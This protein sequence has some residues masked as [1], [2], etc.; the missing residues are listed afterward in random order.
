MRHLFLGLLSFA[1]LAVPAWAV[2]DPQVAI[3]SQF[4]GDEQSMMAALLSDPAEAAAFQKEAA[5]AGNPQAVRDAVVRWRG[6]VAAYASSYVSRQPATNM[7]GR[8]VKEMVEP[9][10]WGALMH[11]LRMMEPGLKKDIVLGMI[12]DGNEKLAKGDASRAMTVISTAR[13]IM[14]DSAEKYLQTPLAK[15]AQADAQRLAAAEAERSKALEA[16]KAKTAEKAKEAE[17]AKTALEAARRA[18]EA[19]ERAKTSPAED[20]KTGPAPVYDGERPK[21]TPVVD[22]G[23][24][25]KDPEPVVGPAPQ[26]GMRPD[27]A[28][29]P[30]KPGEKRPQ[31]IVPSPSTGSDDEEL[32]KMES[33]TGGTKTVKK[34]AMI[35]GGL[36]GLLVGAF[37]G[38]IGMLVG[39]AVGVG[40][41]YAASKYLLRNA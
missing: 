38:P 40:A 10:E 41:G 20:A 18:R 35:G 1:V 9:G 8:S 27:L 31:I 21:E 37:F 33:G 25:P 2:E 3:F 24:G 28:L 34:Y 29:N 13:K 11:F 17:R 32:S 36:L 12:K 16:E 6:R 23:E 22:A 15:N 30:P 7:S 19:A 26:T 14:R 5:A 39:A 4:V